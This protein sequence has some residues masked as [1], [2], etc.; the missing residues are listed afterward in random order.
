VNSQVDLILTT[1]SRSRPAAAWS[2]FATWRRRSRPGG[3]RGAPPRGVDVKQPPAG[4]PG[5]A[6]RPRKGSPGSPG[7]REG[8]WTRSRDPGSRG[9]GSRRAPPGRGRAFQT[10][11][12]GLP[13]SR[14][15]RRGG[16]YINPS[17]RGPAVPG[18]GSG[19]RGPGRALRT[20]PGGLFPPRPGWGS[21]K[22]L[23]GNRGAPARGV[24]VKPPPGDPGDPGF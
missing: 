13:G 24:D 14:A 11:G 3:Y 22:P 18:G 5:G 9:P 4:R 12:P 23:P 19:D 17:R 16:F 10:L 8:S 21:Q 15:R 1:T 2:D 7:P 6:P 20:S